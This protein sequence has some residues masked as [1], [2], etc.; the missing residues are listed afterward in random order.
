MA[1]VKIN[2]KLLTDRTSK[3]FQKMLPKLD[4]AFKNTIASNEFP[5]DGTT[6]RRSGEVVSSPRNIIDLG[7]FANSQSFASID[8]TL[9]VFSWSVAYAIYI[10][11]GYTTRSGRVVE[12]RDWLSAT[13]NNF[14]VLDSYASELRKLL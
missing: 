9:A 10:F 6:K 12:G 3:A 7:A 8:L 2:E 11:Y 1:I 14:S 4:A 13:L 5:W